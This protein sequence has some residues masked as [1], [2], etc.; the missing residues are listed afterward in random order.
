MSA[1]CPSI[2]YAGDNGRGC[3]GGGLQECWC[4]SGSGQQINR[5]NFS[6]LLGCPRARRSGFPKVHVH[7]RDNGM[8]II[9]CFSKEVQTVSMLLCYSIH[10][11]GIQFLG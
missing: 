6:H 10:V 9:S 3:V 7:V 11:C 2:A 4:W 1:M 8:L 5:T